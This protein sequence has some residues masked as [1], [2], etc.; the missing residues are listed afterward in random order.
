M[1]RFRDRKILI[2]EDE[3]LIVQVWMI[4]FE[5]AGYRNIRQAETG[6]EGLQIAREWRPDLIISDVM[7]P[8]PDGFDIFNELFLDPRTLST[9]FIMASGCAP[10]PQPEFSDKLST[11]GVSVYL[12]K[13]FDPRE[14]VACAQKVFTEAEK[15]TLKGL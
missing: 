14:L 12:K 2:I 9:R 15:E 1:N 6:L 3:R 7:H 4:Y 13:P 10:S 5:Q 11:A 8:G